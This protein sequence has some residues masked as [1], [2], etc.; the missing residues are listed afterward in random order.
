MKKEFCCCCFFYFIFPLNLLVKHTN[1]E[2]EQ[3]RGRMQPSL[4]I[5]QLIF[6][7][8]PHGLNLVRFDSVFIIFGFTRAC[9]CALFLFRPAH[10]R[11]F[12]HTF[13]FQFIMCEWRAFIHSFIHSFFFLFYFL[14]LFVDWPRCQRPLFMR[15]YSSWYMVYFVSLFLSH[16]NRLLRY[17]MGGKCSPYSH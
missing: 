11:S 2:S 10:F 4:N 12:D 8:F 16:M 14:S 13:P 1:A 15:S 17:S 7:H 5:Y 6:L 3:R 9:V